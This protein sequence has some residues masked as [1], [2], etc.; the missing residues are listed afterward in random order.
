[1][2]N[3]NSLVLGTRLRQY[4]I[5]SILGQGGFGITYLAEDEDLQ[6]KVAIKECYPGM[7]VSRQGTTVVPTTSEGE[8]DYNW[9]L[10]KFRD[11][12]TTL[13]KFKHPGIVQVLQIIKDENNTAYMV[14]EFV[15][16]QSFE[17]WLK[18]LDQLPNEKQLRALTE[19][20][21]QR[22]RSDP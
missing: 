10:K 20:L 21:F 14:L 19:P 8:A 16:G 13:A 18:G 17:S 12:A 15:E 11:E 3:L 9:A 1:M 6:R 7:F 4:R 22:P 2:D 5:D